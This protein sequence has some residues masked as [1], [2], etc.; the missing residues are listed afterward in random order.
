[1]YKLLHIHNNITFSWDSNKFLSEKIYNEVIFIGESSEYVLSKLNQLPF[2]YK[3]FNNNEIDLIVKYTDGF[4]AVF[5]YNLDEVKI[6][7]LLK[8]K[9]HVKAIARFFGYELYAVNAKKYLSENTWRFYAPAKKSLLSFIKALCL[10]IIRKIKILLNIEYKLQFDNQKSIYKRLDAIMMISKTEYEEL[11][12]S[13]Y[14]PKL[15]EMQF[16]NHENEPHQLNIN[17]QKQNK[18]IIGNSGSRWN[19][20]IDILDSIKRTENKSKIEFYLFFSYENGTVYSNEVKSIAQKINNVYLI[21]EFLDKEKFENIYKNASAL[22]IN[23]YRQHAL[24]NVITAIKFGCK[25]YL[26][27]RSSSYHWL[28]SLG[29]LISEV[30]ELSLDVESGN[31]KLT[32]EQQQ[33]NYN[34]FLVTMKNYSVSDFVDRVLDVLKSS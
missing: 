28:V 12:S 9:P 24:G 21:E 16:T 22:V 8:L 2:K 19:N 33:H 15:I 27:K 29:F 25:I 7:I 18:I 1:M 23:S 17:N 32:P 4:D 14:L 30:D 6:P 26:N 31:I 13:F 10:L 3:L 5:F 34:C 11:S 20:H